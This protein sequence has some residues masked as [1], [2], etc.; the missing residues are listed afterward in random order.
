MN[1]ETIARLLQ[2][3]IALIIFGACV[4]FKE[5]FFTKK[6]SKKLFLMESSWKKFAVISTLIIPFI[7]SLQLWIKFY[8][9]Y[10]LSA[11][12]IL[13]G[14]SLF[15]ISLC[16]LLLKL[17]KYNRAHIKVTVEKKARTKTKIIL[18]LVLCLLITLLD[19]LAVTLLILTAEVQFFFVVFVFSF[20][21][22]IVMVYAVNQR[23][24]FKD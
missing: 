2:I 11:N 8:D 6:F 3:A 4:A 22:A 10:P 24:M 1:E 17:Y 23:T 13:A 15:L 9:K 12:I 7:S 18:V 19:L 5:V 14:G 16:S 21:L 20:A